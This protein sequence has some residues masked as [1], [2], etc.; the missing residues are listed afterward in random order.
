M[1]R[2]FHRVAI[3]NRGEAAMRFVHAARELT[4]QDLPVH[5]IALHTD[6]DRHALFVREA[7]ESYDLGPATFV[8]IRDAQRKHTYLDYARLE[9]ALVQTRAD[10]VW[11]GW[12]FVA[13]H[14]EFA[15]LCDRLGVVFIGPPGDVMRRLGDKITSKH[16]AEDADVPVVAW[17]GGPVETLDEARAHARRIGF[18][19]MLKA[20]AGGG[21]RGIRFLRSEDELPEAF[22]RARNEALRAFGDPTVFIERCA[23]GA[24]HVEVQIV[25]D[26]AG[27]VWALGARDCTVQRRN[28]K[29]VEEAPSPA[30]VPAT[31]RT[32]RA[33]AVRIAR[34]AGYRNAGTVEFLFDHATQQYWFME[35]NARLQVEHPVTELTTG[36]DLVK[37]Q[38]RL[39]R[40]ELLEGE[41]PPTRGHAIEVRLNAEDPDAGFAPAPG[42]VQVF[43]FPGGPGIRVDTGV[44][45]GDTIPQEFDSM[46]AKVI[47]WGRDRGEALARLRRTLAQSR[48]VV[49]DGTTNKAFLL[50]LLARPELAA[51]T[52]D[53]GWLDRL[54][55]SG[56]LAPKQHAD[57]ALLRAAIE[58]CEAETAV[59]LARFFASASRGRPQARTEVGRSVELGYAGHTYTF[60]VF[61]LGPSRYV[62]DVGGRRLD[63]TI[64][65]LDR[66]PIRD[67]RGQGTDW[68]MTVGSRRHRVLLVPQ[69]IRYLVEVDGVAY[70]ISRDSAGIVRAGGPSLVASVAVKEGDIV[71]A[72]DRLLV[73]EAMKMEVTVAAPCAGRVRDVRVSPNV[74]VGTGAPLLAI[75]PLDAEGT[76]T[77]ADRV[78]FE[79]LD[80]APS[81]PASE[82]RAGLVAEFRALMLGYDLDQTA[83]Q[84]TL[85]AWNR[86]SRDPDADSQRVADECECELFGM[87]AD[88]CALFARNPADA[89][90]CEHGHVSA[91]EYLFTYLRTLDA[92]GDRLPPAFVA[93]LQ[94][95]VA[96]YGVRSLE[97]S[98]ALRDSL[99]RIFKARQRLDEQVGPVLTL[100]EQHLERAR[101]EAGRLAC[102]FRS[103]L[104]RLIAVTPHL[105]PSVNDLA[106][107]V[108]YR[109]FELPVLER[110][111]DAVFAAARAD[112]DHLASNPAGAD[113]QE[114]VDRL[115]D[116]PQ[117]LATLL[118]ARFGE[119]SAPMRQLMLEVLTR[120][121][122]RLRGVR[123][124][125]TVTRADRAFTTLDLGGGERAFHVVTAHAEFEDAA[126]ILESGRPLIER[127]PADEDLALDLYLWWEGPLGDADR[128][129][130]LVRDA[131]N[132]AR[133]PRPL[134]RVVAVVSGPQAGLGMGGMQHFT[135]AW[136]D[137]AYEEDRFFR[138]LH[139][140]IAERLHLWRLSNFDVTR[141]ASPEDIYAVHAVAKENPRDER[142][143]AV[144]EVRDLT[145]VRDIT[146]RAVQFPHLE[147]MLFEALAVIRRFQAHR[148]PDRRLHW[149]RVLL[150]VWPPFRLPPEE[151]NDLVGRIVPATEG[152]GIEDLWIRAQVPGDGGDLA[153]TVIAIGRPDSA[154]TIT[155]REPPSRPMPPL[156]P[157]EQKVV[158]SRQQGVA[159]PYDLV[160]MLT[161]P[162]DGRRQGPP[163]FPPGEFV[164]HDLDDEGHLVAVE[165]PPGRNRSNIIVGVIR[166]FTR[167]HPE[168][169]TRVALLGDPSR[170][171]G[172]LAEPECRRITAALDLAEEKGAPVEWFALSAG[173]R[174]SMDS[175][176]ENMDWIALVLRR[177]V[178]FTQ[179]GGEI[180]IVVNGINV[181]A[182]PYWNAEATMLMHTRGVLIMTPESAMVLTGKRALDYSGGVSAEDNQGI[183]GYERIMG[184]NGQGQ[185]FARDLADACRILLRHYDH[186]LVVP[187]ERF[188]R[189]AITADPIDRDV[190]SFPYGHDAHGFSTVGDVFSDEK[191]PGRKR[192]FDMRKVMAAVAD[193][194][195]PPLER[196]LGWRDAENAIVWDS[197]LGGHPITLVGIESR[198]LQ[199]F[200]FVPADGPDQ[201]TAGTLFPQSSRK[202]ARAIN[203]ASG[204]R[205]VV[206]LANLSGFDGSPESLRLWQL[207]YGAEIGRAVVNFDGPMVFCV[208]SRYHGGAFVVF[209]KALNPNLEVAAL[210]GTYASVIGGA[211]AAAVVFAREVERRTTED[212]EVQEIDRQIAAAGGTERARLRARKA[213]IVKT[214]RSARLGEVADEFDRIHSVHRAREV[215]S[216]HHIVPPA[217]LRPYLVEAVERGMERS[218]RP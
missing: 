120:R 88:V 45:E 49:R 19:A 58:A 122:Y 109:L 27:T 61:C 139:P 194:D 5:T 89:D 148:A 18:P 170:D 73:L 135:F 29:V 67:R 141:L 8:D 168:G 177:I 71:E 11:V 149:N 176:T 48:V 126:G 167:K 55:T 70:R 121:Y 132:S 41:P 78:E 199:R 174:I 32:L 87:F 191:N 164:E 166:N 16:I 101:R 105:C 113:R 159:Y 134:Q 182:Q 158:R 9:T 65:Q 98:D 119:A 118:M 129:A 152:L 47:A 202:L 46:L 103:R 161:S 217:R 178:R 79:G 22:Q 218:L 21:G 114:R 143:V 10:A 2:D 31:E 137:G 198:P 97:P 84:R 117:P 25:G 133:L 188:P 180:N 189:R 72:G 138:G 207:E 212:P 155:Y 110:A 62:V 63:V 112:L 107:D 186:T 26:D 195:H 215:G 169:M 211:P 35:V 206:V 68:R 115:V 7:D 91:E 92:S 14:A 131:L 51:S 201:W 66:S 83:L 179:R 100:L 146:G 136:K 150:Y 54:V 163:D 216:V 74:Q 1:P 44:A 43:R 181:G 96:Y 86:V 69:G 160:Q 156:T 197:H 157:Y 56:T 204:N 23:Q 147:R 127:Y 33:A 203:A 64:H 209:S 24:R 50:D 172:A 77:P 76:G 85:S 214:V 13:E 140:M 175:G 165:R 185:Y 3:I 142:L 81:A 42:V 173:A 75:E 60:H 4:G 59:D 12:G 125:E 108:R 171:L 196:W 90:L 190:R 104:D 184:P 95:A 6:P 106:R 52:Y 205:P 53:V 193:Q 37:L 153:D 111:R 39:A 36:L 28:Q 116:C 200:G 124:V 80:C 93:T 40:G 94:R 208:V 30:L 20:T 99:F 213:E 210:E 151:L 38:V 82:L 57:I 130:S 144:A 34:A 183:G 145:P 154:L 123:N 15:D 128:N 162:R 102:D 192:P 17:S 187:G